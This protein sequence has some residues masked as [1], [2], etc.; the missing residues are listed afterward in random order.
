MDQNTKNL[1]ECTGAHAPMKNASER[2]NAY[3]WNDIYLTPPIRGFSTVGSH[4]RVSEGAGAPR[5][6]TMAF[7]MGGRVNWRGDY[8]LG[9]RRFLEISIGEAGD[10]PRSKIPRLKIML[11]HLK[12]PQD[13]K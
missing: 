4:R 5:F 13:V 10:Y 3:L 6:Y 2:Y 12:V 11:D 9:L 8:F 1:Y 7:P